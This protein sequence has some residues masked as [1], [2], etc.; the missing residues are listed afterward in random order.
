MNNYFGTAAE[1]LLDDELTAQKAGTL[2]YLATELGED[3]EL[4]DSIDHRVNSYI[5][6]TTDDLKG[7]PV[8]D[9]VE[10][11]EL[12][13]ILTRREERFRNSIKSA[14]DELNQSDEE[15][16]E[17]LQQSYLHSNQDNLVKDGEPVNI[18]RD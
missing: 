12:R 17:N 11:S 3:H 6:S 14:F 5:D 1:Y 16:I 8:N 18:T 7:F 9:D 13:A 10:I 2:I 15:L 4:Y